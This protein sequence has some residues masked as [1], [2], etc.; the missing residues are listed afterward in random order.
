MGVN[1]RNSDPDRV[2]HIHPAVWPQWPFDEAPKVREQS[3]PIYN[4]Q[5]D[6]NLR[7]S[8]LDGVR[9]AA[10]V[11][12]PRA[13]G[14]KF[15][16]L[17]A[18]SPYTKDLQISNVPIA[19]N[20]AGITEFWVPR[21][22][23]HII[24]DSRG[25]NDSEGKFD[26]RGPIE[27]QDFIE[28]IDWAA[29]QPWCNGSVG[30]V[31]CSYFSLVMLLA[32]IH[33]PEPLKAIFPYDA[34]TDKYRHLYYP[35]GIPQTGYMWMWFSAMSNLHF[36]SGRSKDLSGLQD[37]MREGLGF[38]HPYDGEHHWTVSPQPHI[39]KI[40]IPTYFGSDWSFYWDHLPGA[41]AG[42]EGVRDIP[43]RMLIGPK[44][45]PWRPFG[46]YH[47]EALRWYDHWLK[48]M[49][50][51]VM[52][53]P[54][55]QLYV[56]GEDR[57]RGETEW[58][59]ARA[60]WKKFFL[61]GGSGGLEGS[62]SENGGAT[63]ERTYVNDPMNREWRYGNPRLVYRTEPM[64]S[65]MELTGPLFMHLV[66]RSSIE[67]TDWI[68]T[69]LDES[70]NGEV[71]ILTRGCLRAS[72]RDL[73]E[74]K[75][76]PG[77]PWHPHTRSVPLIPNQEEVFEIEVV[78]TSNLFQPGHRVRLEISSCASAVDRV[79]YLDTL[80]IRAEN[81]VIEGGA[82]SYLLASVIPR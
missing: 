63:G 77:R 23:V 28:L 49:D 79:A 53:G 25:T 67:D 55:I 57:W 80:P 39:D 73:D 46:A 20:E 70:P 4:I 3:A 30:M 36:S 71:R 64:S 24:V 66:G 43:K 34:W 8:M 47:Q 35:G 17:L 52:D 72:H 19:Q 60:E 41:F 45:H 48:G 14:Q 29:S 37:M 2:R 22:Y 82:G 78:P 81:T 38:E 50:T 9:L 18:I 65:P 44:P 15:P 61:G 59:P 69:L 76:R 6:T 68:V 10:D 54:P 58:P 27:Q 40:K 21:G 56:Q 13:P 7:I 75:S 33:Q 16:A 11:Y 42:W 51:G 1:Y 5:S 74:E 26:N 31:G 12:R 32:A 62:L